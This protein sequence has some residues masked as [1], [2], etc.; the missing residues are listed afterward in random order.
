MA[1]LQDILGQLTDMGITSQ[2]TAYSDLSD[3]GAPQIASGLQSY[4]DLEGEDLPA[5]MFQG[6][7]SDLLQ[8]GLGKTYSPMLE[9]SGG[10][11][12]SKLQGQMGGKEAREAYGGF[13]GSGGQRQFA[14]GAKDVYGKGMAD[15]LSRTGEQRAKGLQG[16]Q[17]VINQWR[18]SAMK[19]K[20]YQ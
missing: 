7:S 19:I 16:I 6:I 5:H 3:I 9:A 17:D 2:G 15:V 1:L 18:E 8:A 12:L 14:T 20:G 11:L 13:A 4:F 10:S